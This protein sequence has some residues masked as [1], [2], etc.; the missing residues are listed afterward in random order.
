MG[1]TGVEEIGGFPATVTVPLTGPWTVS[2]N[3]TRFS[4]SVLV[5]ASVPAS[6][7][8]IERQRPL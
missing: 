6:K 7:V 3:V 8:V 2:W 1:G 4:G 5:A